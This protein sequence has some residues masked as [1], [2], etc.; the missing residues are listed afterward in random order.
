MTNLYLKLTGKLSA[1]IGKFDKYSI[2]HLNFLSSGYVCQKCGGTLM[3]WW[4]AADVKCYS[5]DEKEVPLLS[6]RANGNFFECPRCKYRWEIRTITKS[7]A[8][9]R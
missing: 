1:E 3:N 5:V 9:E 6:A 8:A 2:E 7:S 4:G